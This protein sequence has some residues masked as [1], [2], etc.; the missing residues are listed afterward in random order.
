MDHRQQ[1]DSDSDD[2]SNWAAVE[3]VILAR[4]PELVVEDITGNKRKHGERNSAVFEEDGNKCKDSA[5]VVED[6]NKLK[7]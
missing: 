4:A 5:A 6:R 7:V 2:N 3:A 1:F